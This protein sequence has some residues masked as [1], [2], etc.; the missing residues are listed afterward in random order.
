MTPESTI[1]AFER[2]LDAYSC[3]PSNAEAFNALAAILAPSLFKGQGSFFDHAC[4]H[5][6]KA[7]GGDLFPALLSFMDQLTGSGDIQGAQPGS[8]AEWRSATL[9]LELFTE[10]DGDDPAILFGL[11][12]LRDALAAL[13][14]VPRDC[15]AI[16]PLALDLRLARAGFDLFRFAMLPTQIGSIDLD[17]LRAANPTVEASPSRFTPWRALCYS[18]AFEP[19]AAP[20]DFSSIARMALSTSPI[21]APVAYLGAGGQPREARACASLACGPFSACSMAFEPE[22]AQIESDLARINLAYGPRA[23][24]LRAIVEPQSS[25]RSLATFG[26]EQSPIESFALTICDADGSI[27]DAI[28]TPPGPECLAL[29]HALVSGSGIPVVVAPPTP[30]LHGPTG[31]RLWASP[32]GHA[33]FDVFVWR[34]RVLGAVDKL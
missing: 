16:G 17:A 5:A 33:E 28:E 22:R 20:P 23:A 12:P 4:E 30:T 2:A 19:G 3:S 14:G 24:A 7:R 8:V 11:D 10:E 21:E 6:A 26:E 25:T 31:E 13:H 29:I 27:I 34:A 18:C 1:K 15:I 32:A 9:L